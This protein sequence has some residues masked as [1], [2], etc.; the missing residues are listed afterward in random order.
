M[1]VYQDSKR[2]HAVNT[3]GDLHGLQG[4]N[5]THELT[6]EAAYKELRR[7]SH[8]GNYS[9]VQMLAKML[10]K[11]RGEKPSPELYLALILANTDPQHGSPAEVARLLQEMVN[12]RLTPD[13]SS[14]HAALRVG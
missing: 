9:R 13:S 1:E 2:T 10:M 7:A 5:R 14:Y 6:N 8:A 11:E 4:R 3:P 12:D